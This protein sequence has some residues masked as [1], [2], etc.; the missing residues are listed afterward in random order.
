MGMLELSANCVF[1]ICRNNWLYFVYA[2]VLFLSCLEWGSENSM[3]NLRIRDEG[4]EAN[5]IEAN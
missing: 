3:A 1:Q 5:R 2:L 4:T